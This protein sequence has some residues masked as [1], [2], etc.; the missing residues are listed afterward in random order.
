MEVINNGG[1][2]HFII[3]KEYHWEVNRRQLQVLIN[4]PFSHRKKTN[5]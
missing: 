1:E 5:I 3:R 4:I 2:E